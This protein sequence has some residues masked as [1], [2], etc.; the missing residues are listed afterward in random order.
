M[1]VLGYGSMVKASSL[2]PV[3]EAKYADGARW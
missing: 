3:N 2:Q 1:P